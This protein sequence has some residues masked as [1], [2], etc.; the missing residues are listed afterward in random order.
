M[1]NAI[2]MRAPRELYNQDCTLLTLY[3]YL[4][5]HK[6]DTLA[7]VVDAV[8]AFAKRHS[9]PQATFMLAGRQRGHRGRDQHRRQA[10]QLQM[11]LLVYAAVIVL[12]FVTFRSWRAV[13]ARCCR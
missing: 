8:E 11:L 7:R 1:L 5:D 13:C 9:S 12:A 6:A 4:K 2:T 3:V 10:R